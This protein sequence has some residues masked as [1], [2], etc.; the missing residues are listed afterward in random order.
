M[1]K[2]FQVFKSELIAVESGASCI[3]GPYL[4]GEMED[5]VTCPFLIINCLRNRD[6]KGM[7]NMELSS[8]KHVKRGSGRRLGEAARVGHSEECRPATCLGR[9][10]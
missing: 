2:L 10:L 1:I 6:G 8:E 4:L 9:W 5:E 3:P 7:C